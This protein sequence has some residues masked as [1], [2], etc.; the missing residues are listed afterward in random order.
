MASLV[1]SDSGTELFYVDSGAPNDA[2]DYV[3]IFAIHG[4]MF[5]A[6]KSAPYPV[7]HVPSQ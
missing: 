2:V 5:T 3:T 6:R 1:V 4:T 7:T